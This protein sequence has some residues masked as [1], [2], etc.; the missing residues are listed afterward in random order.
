VIRLGLRLAVNGGREAAVRL[1]ILV[2]AVGLGVGLLLIAVSGI[3]A[4]NTQNDRYA[5]FSTGLSS[6]GISSAHAGSDPLW[7]V[8]RADRFDGQLIAR[9]D[10]AAASGPSSPVPPGIPRLPGPGEYYASPALSALLRSTPADQLAARYPGHLTGTIG[11]SALPAPD[12]LVVVVG[13]TVA[14]MRQI[15]HAAS[16][17][18]IATTAPSSCQGEGQCLVGIGIRASG[19]DLIFSVVALAMLFPVLIFIGTATRLSAARREQ[20][21][22]AMRLAGATPRQIS[23]I[24]AVESSVA[25]AA[26]AGLGFALFFVLRDPI[27]LIPFTGARFFTSDLALS[28]PD[29]LTVAIGVPAAAVV[30]ARLALRRVHISPLGV[31]RR[32]TPKQPRFWRVLPLL[33]GLAELG[34]FFVHG[35]PATTPGQ[36]QAFTPGFLLVM[37]GLVV[38]GPWLTMIGAKI[39]AGRTARPGSLIAA[40]RLADNPRGGFRAVSGLVLALFVTTVAVAIIG[41]QNAHRT[42]PIDGPAAAS[43]VSAQFGQDSNTAP[44]A[45]A[46]SATLLAKLHDVAGVGGIVEAHQYPGLTISPATL[47]IAQSFGGIRAGVVSCAQLASMPVF[48]RC[49]A[50]AAAAVIPAYGLFGTSLKGITWSAAGPSVVQ[51]LSRGVISVN[52]ATDGSQA[53]VERTR[54]LL[55]SAYPGVGLPETFA[56]NSAENNL[57]DNQYQQ[58]ADVVMLTSLP[59]AGCTLAASVAAGLA[60]RKRPFSLLR[61]AGSPLGVLRRVVALESAVPLLVVAVVS[62]GIGFATS[63]MFAQAQ[64]GY[65]LVA[66]SLE[67]YFITCGGIIVSL[68]IIAATFPL[69]SRITGPEVARND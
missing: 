62:I 29:V 31:T 38:A 20:R 11:N 23:M 55:E 63:A 59:I 37:V 45:P 57:R 36:I 58:L 47:G 3:N 10:V 16:A 18:S 52:V 68:A 21:F 61:L 22:A 69:L 12:S 25:A 39:M 30:V 13:R 64:L 32:V 1:A 34:F 44:T 33:A 5:W 41:A 54:T 43:V 24:A 40:R 9:V 49:P 2:A 19:I 50:G 48:G 46:A 7:F 27:S 67:Y 15:N 4:V 14:Q 8:V 65:P 53:A 17:T 26:G 51:A 35:R 56:E 28:L 60:D 66:P 42:R 6:S